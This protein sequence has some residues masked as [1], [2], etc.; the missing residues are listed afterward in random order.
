MRQ[1][2]VEG[3]VIVLEELAA[4][5]LT[6]YGTVLIG[7]AQHGVQDLLGSMEIL[8]PDFLPVPADD[9][10]KISVPVVG[11]ALLHLL[12][13]VLQRIRIQFI[14]RIAE[15]HPFP[16]G[17]DDPGIPCAGNSGIALTDHLKGRHLLPHLL[18]HLGGLIRRAVVD[19]EDLK[20]ISQGKHALKASPQGR[21]LTV[22]YR[23]DY[24]TFFHFVLSQKLASYFR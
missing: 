4:V 24:S 1:I 17:F 16:G 21:C 2:R 15:H 18:Q 5:D 14:V 7:P 22:I 13:I 20:G 6:P 10:G 9:L 3:Q 19:D 11:F 12:Q 23:Y 8:G